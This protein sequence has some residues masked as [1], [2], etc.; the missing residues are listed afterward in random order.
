[1]TDVLRRPIRYTRPS[2]QSYLAALAEQGAPQDYIDVQKMIYRVVR[3]N[4]SAFPNHA[5]QKLTGRPA[6]RFDQFVDDY[7]DVWS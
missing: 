1:M 4:I 7:R 3:L 2:E 5:V 6:T